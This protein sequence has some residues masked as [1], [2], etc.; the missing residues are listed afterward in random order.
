MKAGPLWSRLAA[1]TGIDFVVAILIVAIIREVKDFGTGDLAGASNEVFGT[2]T[3]LLGFAAIF[4]QWFAGTFAARIRQLEGGS[5]RLAAA[6]NG[7]GTILAG[8]L[9]LTV[10]VLFA[11]RTSGSSELAGLATGLLD[12]PTWLFPAAVFVGAG[13][14]VGVRAEGLPVYSQVLVRLS[15]PL[16]AFYVAG[17][18]LMLFQNY[19]WIDDTAYITFLAWVLA[20]SIIGVIRWANLDEVRASTAPAAAPAAIPAPAASPAAPRKAQVRKRR[21]AP[22]T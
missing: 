5:G 20:L 2:A 18:G 3:I 10:G 22:P 8:F 12:G 6:V 11:A 21:P 15:L 14:I 7:S 16:A 9:A 17:A 19:A 1:A 13:G 4:L